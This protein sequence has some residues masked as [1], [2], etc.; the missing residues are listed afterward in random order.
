MRKEYKRSRNILILGIISSIF[1]ALGIALISWYLSLGTRIFTIKIEDLSTPILTDEAVTLLSIGITSLLIGVI[2]SIIAS[3][4]ILLNAFKD[5]KHHHA[6]TTWGILFLILI[7]PIAVIVF[8]AM[9]MKQIKYGYPIIIR[10]RK[11]EIHRPVI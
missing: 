10:P 8:S 4:F 6:E 5:K 3:L 1:V 11:E 7:G 9:A 2:Q